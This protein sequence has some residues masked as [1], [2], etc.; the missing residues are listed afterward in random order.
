MEQYLSIKSNHKNDILMFRLGDFFEMF[1]EDAKLAASELNIALTG[2]DCGMGERAPMCGVPAH[3]VDGYIAKLVAKGHRVALCEQ[4][5]DAKQAKGIVARDV[6]RV[7]TPGTMID[8]DY[9]DAGQHNYIVAMHSN[10]NELAIAVADITTGLFM[11]MTLPAGDEQKLLDE[12][13]R[14]APAE[15]LLAEDFKLRRVVESVLGVRA[16]T[17][18]AWTFAPANAYKCLTDHFG[19]F[20]LEGF[21]LRESA[22]EVPVAGA[23]L[24]YL[25]DTQR[26]AIAQI[27]ALRSYSHNSNLLLDAASRRNLELTASTRDRTKKG[28]LLWVLD[29]TK[30][31]MGARLLRDWVEC[32]LADKGSIDKRLESVAEWVQMPIERAE[33]REHLAGIQDFERVISRLTTR[34][35]S[36]RDL[37]TLRSSLANLPHVEILLNNVQA[38]AN[39]EIRNTFDDLA[40]IH[41]TIQNTISDAPPATVREGGMV[42]SGFDAE[43]D[44]LQHVKANAQSIL[45]E[46]EAREKKETGI[47]SLKVRYNR[48]FGYY[49]EVT[50]THLSKVPA[51]YVRKQTLANCERFFTEELKELEETILGADEKI[52]VLEYE[53]YDKLRRVIIE[54]A[55]RIQFTAQLL[56]TLDALQ[57]L[58]SAA[59]KNNYTRP[60]ITVGS[61]IYI[62]DGRH[63][64]VEHMSD[65]AFVPNDTY[66]GGSESCINSEN[67][68]HVLQNQLSVITGPNMAGKSTYMRQVAL[69]VLMAQIG[70]FVPAAEAEIGIVDRIFTRVGASD[71]LATGQSTFMVEMT[72]VANILNNA[73]QKS[74]VLL[75]EIGRG[76]STFDGLSIAWAVLEFITKKINCKTL[77]ATHYHELTQLEGKLTGVANYCFTAQ[78]DGRNI[79]FLRKLVRGA[80]GQ[81]YGVHVARLAGLPQTVL[82]RANALLRALCDANITNTAASSQSITEISATAVVEEDPMEDAGRKLVEAVSGLEIESMTPLD[83]L[84]FLQKLKELI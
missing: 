15:L 18:P 64:V 46:L 55:T 27:T 30:T 81:S 53:I 37:V 69:I 16:T 11:A 57:S 58:A 66:M 36:A 78:E 60:R 40:D 61:R 72:E 9:L 74:L 68:G 32:P 38:Q 77:F 3:A 35:A 28:S 20:N 54:Q 67:N 83:A 45:T 76:T 44:R 51:R 34:S 80:A 5:E 47:A 7:Y 84:L 59:E 43:L 39:K 48:V 2:R 62:M 42:R 1:F 22:A 71:D 31:S 19:T 12:A 8:G 29:N 73:T 23:L 33:L 41:H 17:V 4:V 25:M 56:S 14:L 50:S 82:K 79:V 65:H 49:I 10:K 21:G 75:D 70:S 6:V 52:V 63:P 26:K 13:V 24:A